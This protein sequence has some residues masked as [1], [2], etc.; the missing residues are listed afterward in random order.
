VHIA[1]IGAGNV[2]GQLGRLWARAGHDVRFAVHDL[3]GP[4]ARALREEGYEVGHTGI[5]VEEAE[6][7]L[8]AI[9]HSALAD[10]IDSGGD[11][12][13]NLVI[14]ATNRIGVELPDGFDSAAEEIA[15]RAAGAVV[16]KAFN[17]IGANR[18][19]QPRFGEQAASMFVC[20][21]DSAA[22][23]IVSGLAKDLG[24]E[25]VDAGPLAN[26]RL[27]EALAELWVSLARGGLGRDLGFRLLRD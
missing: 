16:V 14:D 25:P 3:N 17:T 26:A 24:F 1:V 9:P 12:T 20:G 22:K 15:D 19:A 21:D 23:D 7:V 18:Y 5:A 10:A 2:G 6:V 8:L 13:G 4:R 11:W 27:L